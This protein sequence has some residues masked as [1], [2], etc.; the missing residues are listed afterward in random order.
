MS[1]P[2]RTERWQKLVEITQLMFQHGEIPRAM[3]WMVLVLIPKGNTDT[4]GV[5]LL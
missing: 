1:P 4:R 3:G 5:G 2:P